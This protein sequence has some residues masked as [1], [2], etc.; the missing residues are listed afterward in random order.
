MKKILCLILGALLL[1]GCTVEKI[2]EHLVVDGWIEDGGYPIVILTSSVAIVDGT[3]DYEDLSKHVLR[4]ATVTVSDGDNQVVLMGMRN[5]D[6]FPPYIYT[7]SK[8]KGQAGKTYTLKVRY[9]D[10]EASAETTI[11]TPQTLTKLEVNETPEGS[12]IRV[13][14]TPVDGSYYG[15]F[16]KRE[17]KDSSYLAC[18]YS[19]VDGSGLPAD[20]ESLVYRGFDIMGSEYKF[21]Y[22]SGDHVYLRFSTMDQIS[23][24]YW[25]G[26][27]DEWAFSRNPFFP[28]Q[29]TA[30][31]N[32]VGGY[33]CWVGY[34]SSFYEIDIP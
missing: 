29:S 34:G 19:L 17:H 16:T 21:F 32:V 28:A 12:S 3:L 2:D 10:T 13:G 15:F 20:Y 30:P 14:F 6:Y 4:W 25:K 31:S 18:L 7:T 11:P 24:N 23:Y 1:G 5:D 8:I 27:Y 9:G 33:G 22:E 26:L